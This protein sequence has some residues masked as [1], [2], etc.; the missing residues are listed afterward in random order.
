MTSWHNF[1]QIF[2]K[3]F[4][5]N[6]GIVRGH[7]VDQVKW[8]HTVLSKNS[9]ISFTYPRLLYLS[10]MYQYLSK[11]E[12][13]HNCDSNVF[14]VLTF[15]I[16]LTFSELPIMMD[17]LQALDANIVDTRDGL[18]IWPYHINQCIQLLTVLDHVI[19]LEHHLTWKSF[20][21]CLM[22]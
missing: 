3:I 22:K 2:Y 12:L 18:H 8:C 17:D 13:M 5:V 4:H 16:S 14:P 11:E 9:V 7:L 20:H 19:L 10:H 15:F 1:I 6:L 21:Q